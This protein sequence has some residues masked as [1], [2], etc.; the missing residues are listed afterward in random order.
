[1]IYKKNIG[2]IYAANFNYSKTAILYN[3]CFDILST[4]ILQ[5]IKSKLFEAN[6]NWNQQRYITMLSESNK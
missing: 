1:M 2:K 6:N 3:N 5:K 4:N